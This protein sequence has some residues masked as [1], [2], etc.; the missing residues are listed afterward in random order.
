MVEVPSELFS[1]DLETVPL[2]VVEV[3]ISCASSWMGVF[4]LPRGWIVSFA[5]MQRIAIG[6]WLRCALSSRCCSMTRVRAA[7]DMLSTSEGR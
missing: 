2:V 7:F 1:Q 3:V 4:I 6:C 5:S